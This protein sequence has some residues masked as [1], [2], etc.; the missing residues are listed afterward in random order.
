MYLIGFLLSL[1]PIASFSIFYNIHI[2][3]VIAFIGVLIGLL[4]EYS[5][6]CD[7]YY[8]FCKTLCIS[9]LFSYLC[10]LPGKSEHTYSLI[11]HIYLWPFM[12]LIVFII[13]IIAIH[14]RETII[15]LNEG[16]TFIYTVLLYY[17]LYC[18]TINWEIDAKIPLFIAI[19]IPS[20][21]S[22]INVFTYITL[23]NMIRFFLSLWNTII[24][25][26]FSSSFLFS[27]IIQTFQHNGIYGTNY[28]NL[29]Y[30]YILLGLS[31]IYLVNNLFLIIGFLPN[32]S[33]TMNGEYINAIKK[34][35]SD[36]LFRYSCSQVNIKIALIITFMSIILLYVLAAFKFTN[37]NFVIWT[38]ILTYSIVKKF[39]DIDRL[40]TNRF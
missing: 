19:L 15:P 16:I 27:L 3:V 34:V 2:S 29:F 36:H 4:L 7:D 14:D 11:F 38:I 24:I 6:L 31:G 33:N 39:I 26:I 10:F 8:E 13:M 17:W 5:T 30:Q 32:K 18:S 9:S 40:I 12:F 1:I 28:I 35:Y 37:Y 23:S 21:F 20:V 25:I 22:L